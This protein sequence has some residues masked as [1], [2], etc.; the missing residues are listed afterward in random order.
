MLPHSLKSR[1]VSTSSGRQLEMKTVGASVPAPPAAGAL[2][3]AL[4][5]FAP[6]ELAARQGGNRTEMPYEKRVLL[7]G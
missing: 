3:G 2:R 6:V 1:L 4:G 5:A 7:F